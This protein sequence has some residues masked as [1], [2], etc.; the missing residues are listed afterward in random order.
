MAVTY[1]DVFQLLCQL[2]LILEAA[3]TTSILI[4]FWVLVYSTFLFFRVLNQQ[5]QDLVK[6]GNAIRLEELKVWKSNHACVCRMV[7][8]INQCFGLIILIAVSHGFLAF[9]T[10]AYQFFARVIGL[11]QEDDQQFSGLFFLLLVIQEVA[12]LSILICTSHNLTSQVNCLRFTCRF[13]FDV[14]IGINSRRN[15]SGRH[16]FKLTRLPLK[17]KTW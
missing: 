17:F 4:L 13:T 1:S 2:Q 10:N 3:T 8:W 5:I 12:F 15:T 9:I 11:D 7:H 14:E 6:P 16:C